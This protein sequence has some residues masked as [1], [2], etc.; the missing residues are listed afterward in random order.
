MRGTAEDPAGGW[1]HARGS[2]LAQGGP[3]TPE[4]EAPHPTR[5][6]GGAAL[7]VLAAPAPPSA[8]SARTPPGPRPGRPSPPRRATPQPGGRSR[9]R[10]SPRCPPY[11]SRAADP[12]AGAPDQQAP[13]CAGARGGGHRRSSAR[14]AAATSRRVALRSPITQ[15]PGTA[16]RAAE[17]RGETTGRWWW[18]R[19][20]RSGSDSR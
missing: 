12:Q 2:L 18:L 20:A 5:C 8:S 19:P 7:S 15:R 4:D 9:N 16:S 6:P 1:T 10:R 13:R 17:G 14:A 11:L 3:P